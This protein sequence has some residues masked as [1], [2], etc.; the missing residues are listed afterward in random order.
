MC[1]KKKSSWKQKTN[2]YELEFMKRNCKKVNI[3]RM[4]ADQMLAKC[5][6]FGS[7][8]L[9]MLGLFGVINILSSIHYYSQTIINFM[10]NHW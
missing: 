6:D 8:Q 9:M 7:Y 3:S 4:D 10:P 5:G 1:L 2:E